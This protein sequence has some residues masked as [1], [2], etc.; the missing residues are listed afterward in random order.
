MNKEERLRRKDIENLIGNG[1]F[2]L[3]YGRTLGKKAFTRV[4]NE[5]LEY[6]KQEE[7]IGTDFF[8]LVRINKSGVWIRY[9]DYA[10]GQP[11]WLSYGEIDVSLGSHGFYWTIS[12]TKN[13]TTYRLTKF[14]DRGIHWGFSK[15]ELEGVK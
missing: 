11:V 4:M 9:D 7:E 3:L 6:K 10:E 14:K 5:M 15:E 12:E 1:Q 13:T 2:I 8:S